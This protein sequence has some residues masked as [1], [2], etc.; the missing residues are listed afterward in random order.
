MDKYKQSKLWKHIAALIYD[1]FPILGMFLVTSLFFVLLRSGEEVKPHTIWFQLVLLAEV[2]FYF[3]YSWKTGGQT[4]GMRA[5]KIGI[6]NYSRLNWPQVTLRFITGLLST[7]L[8]GLGL[9]YRSWSP[10]QLTWMDAACS[11]PV[12]DLHIQPVAND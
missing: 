2:F 5:W 11:Q 7:C 6:A 10:K 1:I 9:W 8:L 4:I 3:T 12:I